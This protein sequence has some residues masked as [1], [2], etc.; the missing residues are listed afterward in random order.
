LVTLTRAEGYLTS[1]AIPYGVLTAERCESAP[2]RDVEICPGGPVLLAAVPVKDRICR[3]YRDDRVR[4]Q[5]GFNAALQLVRLQTDMHPFR[6]LK[7]P[8]LGIELD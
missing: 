6:I 5:L 1:H 2:P 4:I 7:S 8:M 3:F